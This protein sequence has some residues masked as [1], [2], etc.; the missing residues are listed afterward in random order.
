VLGVRFWRAKRRLLLGSRRSGVVDDSAPQSGMIDEKGVPVEFSVL[1]RLSQIILRSYNPPPLNTSGVL[2]RAKF[3]QA[4]ILSGDQTNGWHDLFTEG[5]EVVQMT[6]NHTT[7]VS[8][9]QNIAAL[10]AQI[11]AVLERYHMSDEK[12][13]PAA[14][15]VAVRSHSLA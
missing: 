2:M 12:H 14:S 8:D 6:G 13:V 1:Y 7:I 3:P 15:S 11:R 10:S 4:E 5:L 9:E